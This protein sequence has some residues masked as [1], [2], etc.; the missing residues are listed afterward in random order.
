MAKSAGPKTVYCSDLEWEQ[1]RAYAGDAGMTISR[2][3]MACLLAG[4]EDDGTDAG[5]DS[6]PSGRQD[7]SS[8]E[9]LCDEGHP[10]VLSASEQRH[11]YELAKYIAACNYAL[12][13]PIGDMPLG[14][15]EMLYFLVKQED[16]R[17][18]GLVPLG[19]QL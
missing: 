3:V 19:R 5:M 15:R 12:L 4:T 1:I 10:L 2:Y 17:S 16:S 9:R 6:V 13:Q 8:Q 18:Q 11:L 7:T 14:L